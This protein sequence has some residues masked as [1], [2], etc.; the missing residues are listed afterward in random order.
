MIKKE[1][2][3]GDYTFYHLKGIALAKNMR[4]YIEKNV[5]EINEDYQAFVRKLYDVLEEVEKAYDKS[6]ELNIENTAAFTS[7][8]NYLLS[9]IRDVQKYICPNITVDQMVKSEKHSWCNDYI[10]KVYETLENIRIIDLYMNMNHEEMI[11]NY[12]SQLSDLEG[13]ISD[14]I[15]GWNSLLTREDVYHPTIRINLIHGY[16]QQCNKEWALLDHHKCEYVRKLIMDNIQEQS[17]NAKYIVQWFDFA[18]NFEKDLNKTVKYFQQY[19][20]NPD[21][22][23]YYR[24]MLTFFAYGLENSDKTYLRQGI[25]F[26]NKCEELAREIPNRRLLI[27]VYN[28]NGK[29]M[30]KIEK[31]KKYFWKG[32]DYNSALALVPKVKGCI[33]EI[34]KPEIGWISVEEFNIK[35][36]FNPSYNPERIYRRTKDE[37]CRVE[38]VLGFRLE[39]AFAFSV[40]DIKQ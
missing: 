35:I 11:V 29:N 37:G 28:S 38:F 40:S 16:Y 17:D 21:I 5:S 33:A 9:I 30:R 25:D 10:A 27:D 19:V 2:T 4:K 8:M 3:I 26:S 34:V 1:L 36:K 12:E 22:D 7:K 20:A 13:N 24:A 14:A 23:Y 32:R 15:N 6:V 31:F 39:G 18:R